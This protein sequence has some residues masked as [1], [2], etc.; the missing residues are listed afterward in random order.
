MMV[1]IFFRLELLICPFLIEIHHVNT[2]FGKNV[3]KFLW[4]LKQTFT[5][6]FLWFLCYK[7]WII[8]IE[9]YVR[10]DLLTNKVRQ[11]FPWDFQRIKSQQCYVCSWWSFKCHK[12]FFSQEHLFVDVLTLLFNIYLSDHLNLVLAIIIRTINS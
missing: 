10:F 6:T 5:G 7:C 3:K 11:G 1:N 2:I 4:F 9:I 8:M 12:L